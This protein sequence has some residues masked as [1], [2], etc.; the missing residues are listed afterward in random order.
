MTW[1]G[2]GFGPQLLAAERVNSARVGGES[3]GWA[4]VHIKGMPSYSKQHM[5]TTQMS[6]ERALQSRTPD[7]WNRYFRL[8]WWTSFV[9]T[10]CRRLA[11][12]W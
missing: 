12:A 9:G 8:V 3:S 1:L 10:G 7:L 2:S 5:K 11:S 4:A 6:F